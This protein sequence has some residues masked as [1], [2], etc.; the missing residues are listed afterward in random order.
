MHYL[1]IGVKGDARRTAVVVARAIM[2]ELKTQP[3]PPTFSGITVRF[4]D[5][6]PA[7]A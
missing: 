3:G 4:Y 7:A 5:I 2:G 1:F 6:P